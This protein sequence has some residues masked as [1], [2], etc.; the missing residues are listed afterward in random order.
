MFVDLLRESNVNNEHSVA[1]H[2]TYIYGSKW[3][4]SS[5]EMSSKIDNNGWLV[6]LILHWKFEQILIKILWKCWFCRKAFLWSAFLLPE[7]SKRLQN[8]EY[9]PA[10]I[11]MWC[12]CKVVCTWRSR[13][14]RH[15]NAERERK[16]Q[17]TG[18]FIDNWMACPI[19]F[20]R[21]YSTHC[22]AA[23]MFHVQEHKVFDTHTLTHTYTRKKQS[24]FISA[25]FQ[26]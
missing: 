20:H 25:D 19:D 23:S 16:H 8:W 17:L 15:F 1:H 5:I 2:L 10:I 12:N 22:L 7:R 11:I 14:L 18:S 13:C 4:E 3:E 9:C 6:A 21:Q 24:N 26:Y